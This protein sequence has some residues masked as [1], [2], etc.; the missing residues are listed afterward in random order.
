MKTTATAFLCACLSL[1]AAAAFGQADPKGAVDR[2]VKKDWTIEDCR[3]HLANRPGAPKDEATRMQEGRCAELMK[4]DQAARNTDSTASPKSDGAGDQ[5]VK[6]NWTVEECREHMAR[7]GSADAKQDDARA[8][9]ERQCE[10][11][12]KR[13][14]TT[15]T[16]GSADPS[17]KP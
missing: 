10:D 15:G 8:A 3:D 9:M 5:I 14:R 2:T 1:G 7:P 12:M 13:D 11:M 16:N 17:K 6:K 4:N